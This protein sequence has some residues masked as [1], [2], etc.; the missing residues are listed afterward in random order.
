MADLRKIFFIIH[1]HV[2]V[3]G[4]SSVP[5]ILGDDGVVAYQNEGAGQDSN[6]GYDK[7]GEI[8]ARIAIGSIAKRW[9]WWED[10]V[11]PLRAIYA[12]NL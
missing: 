2:G 11:T 12:A 1:F 6:D 8:S 5:A 10:D 9:R 3:G 7:R 4:G